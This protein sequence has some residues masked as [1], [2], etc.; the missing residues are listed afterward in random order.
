MGLGDLAVAV[1][2][3]LVVSRNFPL[4]DGAL[5]FLMTQEIGDHGFRLPMA[6]AYNAA[7]IPFAYS[8]L[9]FYLAAF[10]HVAGGVDLLGLFRA[11]PLVFSWKIFENSIECTLNPPVPT[12]NVKVWVPSGMLTPLMLTDCHVW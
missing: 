1:R 10:L 8:P 2:T 6:T 4:N 12:R 5:F 3:F 7:N 9:G 11:L